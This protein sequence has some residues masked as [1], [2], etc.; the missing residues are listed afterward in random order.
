MLSSWLIRF[1]A[2]ATLVSRSASLAAALSASP[3][4]ATVHVVVAGDKT[5]SLGLIACARSVFQ[6]AAHPDRMVVH[7]I[8]AVDNLADLRAAVVCALGPPKSSGGKYRYHLVPFDESSEL[9]RHVVALISVRHKQKQ[10]LA[11]AYNYAR[12]YLDRLLPRNVRKVVWLDSDAIVLSDVAELFDGSLAEDG[13][14][15]IAAVPRDEKVICGSFL[16]CSNPEAMALLAQRKVT[17]GDLN[18]FNAGVV[19]IHLERWRSAELGKLV[20]AWLLANTQTP[21]FA[22]GTNPPFVLAT[23]G[24]FERID[25]GWNCQVGSGALPRGPRRAARRRAGAAQARQAAGQGQA[26]AAPRLAGG[27]RRRGSRAGRRA[28]REDPALER[29]QETLVAGRIFAGA[30]GVFARRVDARLRVAK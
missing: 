26:A 20:E 14:N 10:Y 16:N 15:V 23:A 30:H 21:I 19:V 13:G 5:H 17:F 3:P 1:A 18:A 6:T 22:L 29:R 28:R 2:L 7:L 9:A 8:V 25:A 12:F 24:K 11:S 27:R 4:A